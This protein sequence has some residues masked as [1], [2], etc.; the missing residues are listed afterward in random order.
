[1]LRK[2]TAGYALIFFMSV[3]FA[4]FG[5]VQMFILFA[6]MLA[7]FWYAIRPAPRDVFFGVV[8]ALSTFLLT[9]PILEQFYLFRL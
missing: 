6:A 1:M 4:I 5:F 3:L 2:I 9:D 7:V 8:L